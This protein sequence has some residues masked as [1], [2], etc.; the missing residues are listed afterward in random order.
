MTWNNSLYFVTQ[1]GR[2]NVLVTQLGILKIKEN[3]GE[4]NTI[5]FPEN[6]GFLSWFTGGKKRKRDGKCGWKNCKYELLHSY[7]ILNPIL[8]I[9]ITVYI[10]Y[11]I[12]HQCN[13]QTITNRNSHSYY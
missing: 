10:T 13:A 9:V 1:G 7:I 12:I 4:K 8:D 6:A 5:F 2:T 11:V 3:L